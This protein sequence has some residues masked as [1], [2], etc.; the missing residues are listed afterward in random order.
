MLILLLNQMLYKL[1]IEFCYSVQLSSS[2]QVSAFCVLHQQMTKKFTTHLMRTT[3]LSLFPDG[4][5]AIRISRHECIDTLLL[6][7]RN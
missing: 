3:K 6:L 7:L 4:E 2:Y 5:N 1:F